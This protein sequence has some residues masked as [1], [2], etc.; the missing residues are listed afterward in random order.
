MTEEKQIYPELKFIKEKIYDKSNFKFSNHKIN[1]ESV[2]YAACSFELNGKKIEHRSSKITP[3]KT[4]QFVTLW[5]R[6]KKGLTEPFSYSDKIDFVIITSKFKNK[7][8]QFIFPKSI[9]IGKGIF[10]TK[11]KLGKLGFR[12]YPTW[13]KTESKQAIKT[14]LW[15]NEFFVE[16]KKDKKAYIEL[17]K[18]FLLIRERTMKENPNLD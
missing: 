14:K 5:K 15:Q 2:E 1:Q 13:N 6:N 11:E 17:L 4:G 3:T 18:N 12:V 10:S 9:L 16:F 8:G 7:I